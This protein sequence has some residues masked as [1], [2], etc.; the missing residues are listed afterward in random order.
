MEGYIILVFSFI[1]LFVGFSLRK[2]VVRHLKKKEYAINITSDEE[3]S[4]LSDSQFVEYIEAYLQENEDG[5][6]SLLKRRVKRRF[7]ET[8]FLTFLLL[9]SYFFMN[10]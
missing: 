1:G 7:S 2:R 3:I 6:E 8:V 4:K 5:L 9:T 10:M